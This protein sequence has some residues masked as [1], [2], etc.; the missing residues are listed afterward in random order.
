MTDLSIVMTGANEF[1]QSIWAVQSIIEDLEGKVNYEIIYVDNKSF[2]PNHDKRDTRKMISDAVDGAF[3]EG[4]FYE[5]LLVKRLADLAIPDNYKSSLYMDLMSIVAQN[6]IGD[7]MSLSQMIN[8][9]ESYYNGIVSQGQNGDLTGD[10]L[11]DKSHVKYV[12]YDAS[13]SH[14]QA[15]NK[16]LGHAQ[17]KI[18]MTPD[19]HMLAPKGSISSMYR[20]YVDHY[21]ELHGAIHLP[22]KYFLSGK[23][24]IYGLK[25]NKPKGFVHYSFSGM[26]DRKG[27]FEVPCMINCSHMCSREIMDDCMLWP[28]ELGI[29]GGGELF[30]NF[31]RG[32]L[33][34][35]TWIYGDSHIYHWAGGSVHRGYCF[36]YW[37]EKRNKAIAIYCFGD[38]EWLNNFMD[39]ESG[40]KEQ[41]DKIKEDVI[42]KC[43]DLRN[44]I[45]CKQ[46]MTIEEWAHKQDKQFV[47]EF[48]E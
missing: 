26:G 40:P 43:R 30:S 10:M 6:T 14:W 3:D 41:R 28:K 7:T 33:G 21:D 9:V 16:G 48:E 31:V 15:K 27:V 42:A 17:G 24:L 45:K 19:A 12:V 34:Y 18:I 36:N 44:M 29:W 38:E 46:K 20:Y 2:H 22:I 23:S 5:D 1:P 8:D 13:Q 32:I 39:N 37:N 4:V 11:K 47:K 25:Y 35:K